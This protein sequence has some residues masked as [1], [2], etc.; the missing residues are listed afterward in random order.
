MKIELELSLEAALVIRI[1]K[2][3]GETNA[4]CADRLLANLLQISID[5][6]NYAQH[7]GPQKRQP[8]DS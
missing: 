8:K 1:L 6:D 2:L 7:F 4:E 5:K 3:R